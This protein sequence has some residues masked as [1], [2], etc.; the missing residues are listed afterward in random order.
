V[1]LLLVPRDAR[2][3]ADFMT[4]VNG[5]IAREAG[6]LH[7]WNEKFWGR[8]Y[9]TIVASEEP[10]AQVARLRYLLETVQGGPGEEARRVAGSQQ[11][12][13]ARRRQIA[14]RLV[15]PSRRRV[16]GETPR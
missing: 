6:R 8:R 1:H 11:H 3:L 4:Y 12:P 10:E 13:G 14:A 15:V 5:N 16:R 7:G 9:R 2:H